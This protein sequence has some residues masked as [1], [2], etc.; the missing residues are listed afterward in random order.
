M[1]ILETKGSQNVEEIVFSG[2]VSHWK[3]GTPLAE[4]VINIF[5]L[6]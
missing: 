4:H 1:D 2:S 3:L 5:K 6:K